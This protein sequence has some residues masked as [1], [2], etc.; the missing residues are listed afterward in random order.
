M[1]MCLPNRYREETGDVYWL[2]LAIR[3]LWPFLF[4]WSAIKPQPRGSLLFFIYCSFQ[5]SELDMYRSW[6]KNRRNS[7]D[8]G[9]GRKKKMYAQRCY[10]IRPWL[11]TRIL[12]RTES[13]Q[14]KSN[15]DEEEEEIQHAHTSSHTL[16]SEA[17]FAFANLVSNWRYDIAVDMPCCRERKK[18][19]K[20]G[21]DTVAWSL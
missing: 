15:A 9:Q 19:K 13:N 17:T 10:Y 12:S 16:S 2:V 11:L 6:P 5:L 3:D 21:K 4:S 8:H 14:N 20:K 18:R 1:T 7:I